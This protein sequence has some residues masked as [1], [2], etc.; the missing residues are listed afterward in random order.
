MAN[1]SIMEVLHQEDMRKNFHIGGNRTRSTS[2]PIDQRFKVSGTFE[3]G[4]SIERLQLEL[5]H[6]EEIL[7]IVKDNSASS[8]VAI[9]Y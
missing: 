8:A 5:D 6:Q 1:Y 4:H 2:K 3:N 7:S 9:Q